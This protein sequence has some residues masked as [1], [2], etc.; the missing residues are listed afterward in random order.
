MA[1]CKDYLK[2]RCIYFVTSPSRMKPHPTNGA[3]EPSGSQSYQQRHCCA[4]NPL[5]RKLFAENN[6]M[7]LCAMQPFNEND[8]MH[9]VIVTREALECHHPVEFEYYGNPKLTSSWLNVALCTYC[10]GS[11]GTKG[12]IDDHLNI[13]W[14]SVLVVCQLCRANGVLLLPWTKRRLG[15]ANA[16]LA[17]C[18]RLPIHVPR[19]SLNAISE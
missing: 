8:V 12:F 19:A 16:R 11:S 17:Q 7:Y 4:V 14:K 18:D 2:P 13:E 3:V 9:G 5:C 6:G 1:A 10:A 15:E